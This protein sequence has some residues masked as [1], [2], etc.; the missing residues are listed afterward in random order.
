MS[1][2]SPS[3]TELNPRLKGFVID[4]L[5]AGEGEWKVIDALMSQ[6]KLDRPQAEAYIRRIGPAVY[7]H[8]CGVYRTHMVIGSCLWALAIWLG[9]A[10]I[11]R[12]L[13]VVAIGMITAGMGY[14]AYGLFG[15]RRCRALLNRGP[16]PVQK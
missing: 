3:V 2:S 5:K 6:A 14:F 15:W 9:F 11:P 4:R 13:I 1:V 16:I 12:G 8:Q 7:R 10:F